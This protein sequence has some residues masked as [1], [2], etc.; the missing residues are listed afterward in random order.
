MTSNHL[1]FLNIDD[2]LILILLNADGM[3]VTAVA[4]QLQLTQ[5]AVTQRLRKMEA[6]FSQKIIERKGRGI[7]LTYFG[8]SI[9]A[10]AKAAISI[11]QSE[12][13]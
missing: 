12:H 3:S 10:R 8:E 13:G 2:L 6:A 1:R 11:L 4:R 9:S 5:P 7:H